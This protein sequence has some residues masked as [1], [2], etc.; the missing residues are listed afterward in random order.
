MPPVI[1]DCD[2]VCIGN[3]AGGYYLIKSAAIAQ[4]DL[5]QFNSAARTGSGPAPH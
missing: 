1:L 2:Y 5:T 3:A 4:A